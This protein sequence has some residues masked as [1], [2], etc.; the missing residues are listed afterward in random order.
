MFS[1]ATYEIDSPLP[2]EMA[3]K[4]RIAKSEKRYLDRRQRTGTQ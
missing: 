3:T 1:G 4:W 2:T